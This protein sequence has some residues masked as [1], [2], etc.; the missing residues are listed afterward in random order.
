MTN[1]KAIR[2]KMKK[3]AKR[4]RKRSSGPS[5]RSLLTKTGAPLKN[6]KVFSASKKNSVSA[7]KRSVRWKHFAKSKRK[8]R[9]LERS[10]RLACAPSNSSKKKSCA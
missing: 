1:W 2:L 6:S 9:E 3:H 7:K 4:R 5:C 10:V 8:S